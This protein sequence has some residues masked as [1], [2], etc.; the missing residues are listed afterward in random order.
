MADDRTYIY[1]L[2]LTR[3]EMVSEGPTPEELKTVHEHFFYLKTLRDEGTVLHAGRTTPQG[4]KTFGVV[5]LKASSEAGAREI[6][7]ADP[8]VK[9][10]VMTAELSRYNVALV[11]S[12]WTEA[13]SE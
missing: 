12:G 1:V 11:G 6:M 10:S 13:E 9:G 7:S 5:I 3:P 2:R 4:D 8:A